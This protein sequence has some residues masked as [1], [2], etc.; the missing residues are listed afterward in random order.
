[1]CVCECDIIVGTD[2]LSGGGMSIVAYYQRPYTSVLDKRKGNS[3]GAPSCKLRGATAH[4]LAY[5]N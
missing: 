2:D 3:P 1:M 5:L 4:G